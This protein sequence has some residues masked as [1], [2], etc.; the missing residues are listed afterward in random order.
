MRLIH[1]RRVDCGFLATLAATLA[2]ALLEVSKYVITWIN[3]E[4]G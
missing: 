4:V 1:L 2:A 3:I